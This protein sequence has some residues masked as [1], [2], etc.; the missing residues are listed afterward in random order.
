MVAPALLTVVAT[1]APAEEAAVVAVFVQLAAMGCSL[2][3]SCVG[4]CIGGGL[5]CSRGGGHS[6]Y[7]RMHNG[8]AARQCFDGT[9]MER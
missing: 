9:K 7:A 5:S 4:A 8:G 3:S 2:G 6:G 1:V